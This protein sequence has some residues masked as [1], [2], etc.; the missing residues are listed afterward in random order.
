MWGFKKDVIKRLNLEARH[1]D[2]EAE[3]YAKCVKM[4]CRIGEVPIDYKKRISP[5]K[6]SSMKHGVSIASR[7]FKEKI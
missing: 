5:S 6:L 1:F 4:G 3:M 7:L 2:I